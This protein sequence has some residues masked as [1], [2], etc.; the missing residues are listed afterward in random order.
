[1]I[2]EP[3]LD[4]GLKKKNHYKQFER[5]VEELEYELDIK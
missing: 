2:H 5:I 4:P 1:M 3:W